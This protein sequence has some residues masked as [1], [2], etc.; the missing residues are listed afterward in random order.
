M[1]F[2]PRTSQQP[3]TLSLRLQSM[4]GVGIGLNPATTSTA[5]SRRRL[6]TVAR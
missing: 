6:V 1:V 3:P 5:A 2:W 4:V